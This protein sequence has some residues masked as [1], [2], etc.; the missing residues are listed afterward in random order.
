MLTFSV[1]VKWVNGENKVVRYPLY[2][3]WVFIYDNYPNFN[4][5]EFD[6]IKSQAGLNSFPISVKEWI[7]KTNAIGE[8]V[9]SDKV[10]YY[11]DI[12]QEL[13]Q[14]DCFIDVKKKNVDMNNELISFLWIVPAAIL[15][16]GVIV[17]VKR[18]RK[19]AKERLL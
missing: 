7:A 11:A 9:A 3:Q 8:L 18:T 6:I 5:N 2:Q 16:I 15:T 13:M 14:Y 17:A 10:H 4:Y 12:K 1:L 19:W